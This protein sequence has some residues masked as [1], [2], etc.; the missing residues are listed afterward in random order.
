MFKTHFE[1]TSKNKIK[2][3]DID[4]IPK[5]FKDKFSGYKND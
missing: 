3:T 5:N 1:N 2:R 4:Y